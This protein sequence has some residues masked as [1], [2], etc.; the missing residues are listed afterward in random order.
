MKHQLVR[1]AL[2]LYPSS[3]RQRY[4]EE[5]EQLILDSQTSNPSLL[6]S[7]RLL[8][9]LAGSG[10]AQRL[11]G[12]GT[13]VRVLTVACACAAIGIA[14]DATTLTPDNTAPFPPTPVGV[15]RLAPSAFLPENMGRVHA[16]IWAFPWNAQTQP[17]RITL[18][19]LPGTSRV[20][21]I[22]GPP[23]TTVLNPHTGRVL[24][25]RRGG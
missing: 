24:A 19:F 3:W 2:F 6:E 5:L 12:H 1:A 23:A 10:L 13:R 15:L 18:W 4:G 21:G 7:G 20:T 14:V 25:I 17:R 11:R 22:S 8:I 16:P 9:D